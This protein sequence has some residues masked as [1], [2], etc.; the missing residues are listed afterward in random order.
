MV[1]A[2]TKPMNDWFHP[3]QQNWEQWFQTQQ[4]QWS[5]FFKEWQNGVGGK[6]SVPGAAVYQQFFT[7]AGQQFL[8]MM[9]QFQQ[10]A[11]Q[12]KPAGDAAQAWSQGMQQFFAKIFQGNSQSAEMTD[13][14]K[15]FMT[16]GEDM[17]KAGNAWVQSFQGGTSF[18]PGFTP[19]ATGFGDFNF[20]PFG[21]YASMPGIGY[22]R[23]KQEAYGELYKRWSA[24]EGML[25]KYNAAMAKVGLESVQKFQDYLVN[26][27]PDALPLTSLK[28]IYVKWVDICEEVYAEFAITKEY[29]D[30]YGNTVNALM[31]CKQ[32]ARKLTDDMLDQLGIPTRQETD[33]LHE[34]QHALRRDNIQ[35]KKDIAALQAAVFK[36][37]KTK[38][39]KKAVNKVVKK[40]VKKVSKAP[41]KTAKKKGK[42]S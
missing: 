16:V 35:L 6:D 5:T 22:T 27:P 32:Q 21:F 36:T 8:D 39:V 3:Q 41:V 38:T 9:Q 13:A 37:K 11:G 4:G 30:L 15:N 20:D 1:T 23:E 10:S 34:R 40:A 14:Y 33:S 25:K 29:T 17:L 31:S 18:A 28:G 12:N 19:G 2:Q 7:Q 42:K 26:P 24:F